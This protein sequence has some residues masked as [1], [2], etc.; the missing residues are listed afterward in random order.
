MSS[1]LFWFHQQEYVSKVHAVVWINLQIFSFNVHFCEES[2]ILRKSVTDF[3]NNKSWI[4]K[5][6][7]NTINLHNISFKYEDMG[8][9]CILKQV[10]IPQ[11]V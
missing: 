4:S 7:V 2:V 10:R 11:I 3:A 5:S 1:K 9:Y 6:V 8:Q